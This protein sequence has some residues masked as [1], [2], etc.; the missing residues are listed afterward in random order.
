MSLIKRKRRTDLAL[1]QSTPR[2]ST[3]GVGLLSPVV[4]SPHNM[5]RQNNDSDINTTVEVNPTIGSDGDLLE[6][7]KIV[8]SRQE[9]GEEEQATAGW[10]LEKNTDYI[11]RYENNAT[12]D[13]DGSFFIYWC[14]PT[15]ADI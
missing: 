4:A 7:H 10:V 9:G 12:A 5:N 8:G 1:N 3:K 15:E 11:I 6:V 2:S 14:T 13:A